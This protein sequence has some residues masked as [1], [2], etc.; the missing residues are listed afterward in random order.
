MSKSKRQGI[1]WFCGEHGIVTEEHIVPQCLFAPSLRNHCQWELGDSCEACNGMFAEHE[2]DFRTFL[3]HASTAPD[4]ASELYYGKISRAWKR[5]KH[6]EREK[7]RL[8]AKVKPSIEFPGRLV[9]YP[10]DGVRFILRKIIRGLSYKYDDN[11]AIP[12]SGVVI[13]EEPMPAFMLT[14][15]DFFTIH[16]DV[17][18]FYGV[19]VEG[20]GIVDGV[21]YN[22]I[23][24]LQFFRTIQFFGFV[25]A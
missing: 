10:D 1:C 6:G 3:V 13:A 21:R 14:D 2:S 4:A 12:D 9:I 22:S 8:I 17:F 7:E 11:R 16:P 25:K 24:I 5:D 20:G 18:R 15:D 23:W 19:V